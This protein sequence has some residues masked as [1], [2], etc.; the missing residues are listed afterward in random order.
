MSLKANL[1]YT[2]RDLAKLASQRGV[3]FEISSDSTRADF[4]NAVYYNA[5]LDEEKTGVPAAITTAQT[6]LETGYG[7][8]VPTDIN[9]G[10]YSYN[11]FGIKASDAPGPAGQVWDWTQ[12]QDPITHEYR[13]ILDKFKAYQNFGESIPGRSSW[14]QNQPRYKKLFTTNDPI[15]W[16]KG[17]KAAGYATEEK[18][19]ILLINVM[20]SEGLK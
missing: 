13:T 7:K 1:E 2:E 11:L 10:Q 20:R 18:Y 9:T 4:V 12:E 3:N 6:I 14:L 17:L 16:A 5:I 8:H 15:E 19:D